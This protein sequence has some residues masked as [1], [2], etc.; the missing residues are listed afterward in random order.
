MKEKEKMY[1]PEVS[2]DDFFSSQ[3]ERDEQKLEKIQKIPLELIDN[4]ENNPFKV[5]NDEEMQR[6]IESIEKYGQITPAVVRPK[7]NGR[8]E[9]VSG[10]RRKKACEIARIETLDCIVR[11]LTDDEATIVMVDSNFQRERILPSERAYAYKMKLEAMK[12]QGQ[13][14]D[15][16]STQGVQKLSV[17]KIGEENGESRE[18]VRRY[19]RLTFLIPEL[20]QL[21]DNMFLEEAKEELKMAM[22]PAVEISY[23]NENE[24]YELLDTME[25]L[26]ATPSHSQARIIRDESE[27]HILTTDR[28]NEILCEEKPNQKEQVKLKYDSIKQYFPKHYTIEQMEKVI[29]NLLKNYQKQWQRKRDDD[30][31]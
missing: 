18:S 21:V 8:Y 13:R 15:L 20:L 28:I 19:I 27:R 7:E 24:Q 16:T 10:H 5:R 11:D 25:L 14:T 3:E 30:Y 12:R 22:L 29:E 4:A 2:V 6:T 26:Q 1:F 31:R 17:E 9:L 23:L